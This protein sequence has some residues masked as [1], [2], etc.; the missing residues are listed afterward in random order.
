MEDYEMGYY[1]G[2]E[3]GIAQEQERIIKL[4]SGEDVTPS[5]KH[6]KEC[7]CTMKTWWVIALI[8]GDNK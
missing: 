3:S 7:R 2:L 4:L 8:K 6:T 5:H 1:S